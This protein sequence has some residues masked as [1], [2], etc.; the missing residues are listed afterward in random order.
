MHVLPLAKRAEVVS[1]LTN[2]G[3]VRATS[4]QTGVHKTTILSLILKLGE[5][6]RWLHNRLVRGLHVG[7]VEADEMHSYVHTREQNLK[8]G[9]LPEHG[10]SSL[11]LAIAS[12]SKLILRS[13][14]WSVEEPIDAA[15]SAEPCDPPEPRPL[16]PRP[17]AP[18]V[19]TKTT[20]TGVRLRAV[21]G[22]KAP[23]RA[24]APRRGQ[25]ID[26]WE[27]LRRAK[28]R[29]EGEEPPK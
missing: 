9:S 21:D 7:R 18:K 22:G 25:Q 11:Y 12:T 8:P 26:L 16:A 3:S 28:E 4:R 20:P 15:L 13:H 29:E 23:Q 1:H 5:G 10:E 14:V 24:P 17:D 27:V 6:C 19:T 2:C